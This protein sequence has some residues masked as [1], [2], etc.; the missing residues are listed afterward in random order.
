MLLP[1]GRINVDYNDKKIYVQGLTKQ[2]VENLPNFD[3][4]EKVD[5]DYEEQ[6]RNISSNSHIIM[7]QEAVYNRGTYNYS[8]EPSLYDIDEQNNQSL[9]LY[10]E[11]LVANKQRHKAGEVS[12]GKHVETETA[13]VAV[14]VEKERVV[15]ERT[16]PTST[17]S[18][19]PKDAFQTVKLFVWKFTKKHL[20]IRKEASNE[21]KFEL[22]KS[23]IGIQS[24]RKRRFDGRV[25]RSIQ[26][27][28]Q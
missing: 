7:T 22:R 27:V 16:N 24:K 20:D 2:Q 6:V 17:T 15:I 9:K 18:S 14:P 8:L 12:I 3:D 13:R 26:M 5:Y 23:W 11:R 28:V 10:E 21:K 25:R 1:I 19:N 4:L